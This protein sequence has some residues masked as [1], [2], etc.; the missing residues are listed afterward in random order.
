MKSD[1]PV[2]GWFADGPSSGIYLSVYEGIKKL[3]AS[4][5]EN[6]HHLSTWKTLVAGGLA[7]QLYWGSCIPFDVLKNRLQAGLIF[8]LIEENSAQEGLFLSGPQCYNVFV[9][10]PRGFDFKWFLVHVY[11]VVNQVLYAKTTAFFKNN[12]KQFWEGS[13]CSTNGPVSKRCEERVLGGLESVRHQRFLQ[14]ISSSYVCSISS[15]F[16]KF[17]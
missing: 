15:S 3:L 4:P 7:G 12:L 17:A 11:I 5:D 2:K 6:P 1:L 8:V 13:F 16:R 9:V 10:P 14:G